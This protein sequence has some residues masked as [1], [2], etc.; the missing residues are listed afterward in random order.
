MSR[1]RG[2]ITNKEK[3]LFVAAAN[4]VLT[5]SDRNQWGQACNGSLRA[6]NHYVADLDVNNW[7]RIQ[8]KIRQYRHLLKELDAVFLAPESLE[9]LDMICQIVNQRHNPKIWQHLQLDD[10]QPVTRDRLLTFL[11]D[12]YFSKVNDTQ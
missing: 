9:Q 2:K 8:S 6:M 11:I 12:W 7:Q 3:P 4:R 5:G 10:H 1:P